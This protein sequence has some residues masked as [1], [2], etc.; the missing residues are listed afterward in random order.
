MP[1]RYRSGS[2]PALNEC[3]DHDVCSAYLR[4]HSTRSGR[5]TPDDS[6]E[7]VFKFACYVSIPIGM[8]YFISGK[9]EVLEAIIKNVRFVQY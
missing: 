9:P 6:A 7:Q 5:S 4:L 1:L 3:F 2:P 8:T